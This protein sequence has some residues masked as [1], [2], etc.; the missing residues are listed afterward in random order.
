MKLV[1]EFLNVLNQD[2]QIDLFHQ[3][4]N[5]LEYKKIH[6]HSIIISK[7]LLK[8]QVNGLAAIVE[9]V[10]EIENPDAMFIVFGFM[11]AKNCLIVSRSKTD[12]INLYPI[13]KK[14]G[15]GG[16]SQAGAAKVKDISSEQLY[17]DLYQ[18][19]HQTLDPALRAEDI[20]TR[21]VF[22][23]NEEWSVKE[24]SIYLEKINHIGAPVINEEGSL[25]GIMTLRD[26]SKARKAD[27]MTAPVK[28][29][30]SRK[31]YTCDKQATI[32]DIGRILR[33]HN[34]GHIPVEEN[35]K[36]IGLVTR[37]DYLENI[38]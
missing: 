38:S 19:L 23:I 5:N 4:L 29:Y 35:K 30:M 3:I 33:Q 34:I 18:Y 36:I 21:N 14:W 28:S 1:R 8:E 37:T 26:I 25:T 2:Y 22:I 9:K 6:G 20:M 32:N 24:A 15:G 12:S 10:F 27:Q 17:N 31:L 16:H 13:M 7:M 11:N